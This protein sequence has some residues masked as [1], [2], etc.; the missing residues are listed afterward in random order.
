MNSGRFVLVCCTYE[1]GMDAPEWGY[2]TSWDT[3]EQAEAAFP[4]ARGFKLIDDV[5]GREWIS[6]DGALVD[7]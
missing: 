5:T 6:G 3:W 1:D 4:I 7:G 2:V